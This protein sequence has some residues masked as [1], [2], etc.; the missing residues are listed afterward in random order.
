[1]RTVALVL[2]LGS[3]WASGCSPRSPQVDTSALSGTGLGSLPT[4]PAGIDAREVSGLPARAIYLAREFRG[5]PIPLGVL[6][7][8]V[9]VAALA[10]GLYTVRVAYRRPPG[11]AAP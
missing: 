5:N 3:V 4:S 7:A 11:D 6:T 1:M 2:L 8:S 10:L 9:L